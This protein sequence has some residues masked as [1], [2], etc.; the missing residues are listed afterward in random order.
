M[1]IDLFIKNYKSRSL[2]KIYEHSIPLFNYNY[3]NNKKFTHF[4]GRFESI[5][6]DYLKICKYLNIEEEKL[7]HTNKTNHLHY[8]NYYNER[9]IIEISDIY[10]NDLINF[11]YSF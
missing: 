1:S 2:E 11:N 6:N 3:F 4:V 10:K 8:K 5:D 9:Q 7:P